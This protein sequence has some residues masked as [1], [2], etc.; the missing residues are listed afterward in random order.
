MDAE[1]GLPMRRTGSERVDGDGSNSD[2]GE[3][4]RGVVKEVM[5]PRAVAVAVAVKTEV[6]TEQQAAPTAP[7]ETDAAPLPPAEA[8]ATAMDATVTPLVNY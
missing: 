3:G 8:T 1:R 5:A 6:K 4:R 2:D 7:M